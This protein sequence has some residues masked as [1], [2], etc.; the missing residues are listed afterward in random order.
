MN[1]HVN[2]SHIGLVVE[3]K[4]DKGAVPLL[5]RRVLHERGLYLEMMGQPVVTHGR[6]AMTAPGGIEGY[7][8]VAAARPGCRVV[9]VVADA[10]DDQ[11]CKLG[12]E[13]LAR[14][15]EITPLPVVIVLAERSFEDWIY[16]SCETLE[17][18]FIEYRP[19]SRGSNEIKIAVAGTGSKYVKPLWQ[20]RLT[21]RIDVELASRRSAS[22]NRLVHKLLEAADII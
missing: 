7:V 3:G 19:H 17:L 20:P 8:A 18:G 4:G 10:D 12:P 22:F 13:L 6:G 5:M 16:A 21:S 1:A 9:F 15:Q 2:T 14:A 11:S